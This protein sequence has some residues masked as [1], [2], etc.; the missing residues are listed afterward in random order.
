MSDI[1][2]NGNRLLSLKDIDGNKPEIFICSG[3]RTAGKTVFW[4]NRLFKRFLKYGEKFALVYRYSYELT[5]AAENFFSVLKRLFYPKY[6][7]IGKCQGRGKYF[8]LFVYKDDEIDS[9]GKPVNPVSCGYAVSLNNVDNVKKASSKLCDVDCMLFDEYQTETGNY[10]KN[11]PELLQSV[12]TSLARGDGEQVR[13]LPTILVSNTVS[14][15][16]PYFLSM[17]IT[18]RLRKDTKYMRGTGFVAE[19]SHNETA[20]EKQKTSG[21]NKALNTRYTQYS[22]GEGYLLDSEN[23]IEQ[24][25]GASRYIATLKYDNN[26]YGVLKYNTG[27]IYVSDKP[28][29]MCPVRICTQLTDHTEGFVL[30]SKSSPIISGLRNAF[31][32]GAV[33]FRNQQS[34]NAFIMSIAPN[35]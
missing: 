12:H 19:F 7:I 2:Y 22:S 21:F 23:F 28:D 3:N 10:L 20:A 16:N 17:G 18:Q 4:N 24:P 27:I 5:D 11:E 29:L 32:I 31:L 35:Y 26:M 33:R 13:Y 1:Y 6:T 8:E 9:N 25:S 30:Y 14:V 15:L 34:K